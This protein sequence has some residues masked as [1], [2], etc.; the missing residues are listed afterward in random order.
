MQVAC[1][2]KSSFSKDF[3]SL[4]VSILTAGTRLRRTHDSLAEC[5]DGVPSVNRGLV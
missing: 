3:G 2:L 4:I 5:S 1:H